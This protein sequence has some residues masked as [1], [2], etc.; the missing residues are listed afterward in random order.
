MSELTLW[1]QYG[2]IADW[3]RRKATPWPKVDGALRFGT[4]R[5]QDGQWQTAAASRGMVT[6]WTPPG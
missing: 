2:C 6:M 3:W 5:R 1:L 4:S